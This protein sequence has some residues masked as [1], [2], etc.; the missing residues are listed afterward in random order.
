LIGSDAVD[1]KTYVGNLLDINDGSL[2]GYNLYVNVVQKVKL[3]IP[4][5]F[6]VTF[7]LG[8]GD[9]DPRSGAGNINK[10]QTMGFFSLTNVWEDSVM[11]D[12]GGISPQGLGSP[13]SRGYREF[14]NT[15]AIQGKVGAWL[16]KPVRLEASFTYLRAMQPI[17]G[18][19]EN[20][21]TEQ[22]S[23]DIGM[24]VDANLIVKIYGNRVIYKAL[25]GVFLPGKGA[26]YLINGVDQ[27]LDVVWELKQVVV[28]KF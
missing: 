5:D 15:I 23:Q 6:G 21:P 2:L 14:E 22:T 10:I 20:G 1:N 16:V 24:E 26:G 25:F 18:W 28:V 19:D 17:Y 12:V 11:P 7:G 13:V 8:S 27:F 3:G 9:S 4:F